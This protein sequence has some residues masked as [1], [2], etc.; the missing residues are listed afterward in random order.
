MNVNMNE[1]NEMIKK[2][3]INI[4]DLYNKVMFHIC[5]CVGV[6]D[7]TR[8]LIEEK[9]NTF[10]TQEE[11][12]RLNKAAVVSA[13]SC[14]ECR[15]DRGEIGYTPYGGFEYWKWYTAQ[16]LMSNEVII[17]IDTIWDNR[18]DNENIRSNFVFKF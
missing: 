7:V 16:S 18:D 1:F 3:N 6:L 14:W 17:S 11:S 10:L 4:A 8:E 5:D 9:V 12:T 13:L 2:E 15:V